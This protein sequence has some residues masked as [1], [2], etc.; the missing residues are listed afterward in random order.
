MRR[1]HLGRDADRIGLERVRVRH[2][3]ADE[4]VAR[5]RDLGDQMRDQAPGARLDRRDPAVES[6]AT[7][8]ETRGRRHQVVDVVVIGCLDRAHRPCR[9]IVRHASAPLRLLRWVRRREQPRLGHARL[10]ERAE[11]GAVQ[12][13]VRHAGRPGPDL[14]RAPPGEGQRLAVRQ[15]LPRG[16]DALVDLAIDPDLDPRPAAALDRDDQVDALVGD[17]DVA[18]QRDGLALGARGGDRDRPVPGGQLVRRAVGA[19]IGDRDRD[20]RRRRGRCRS[21]AACP[22]RRPRRARRT[23]R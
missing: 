11:G 7:L 10:P 22:G 5:P 17:R 9:P 12:R 16:T 21:R 8:A 14:D 4:P 6:K 18:R 1:K 20:R 23:W 15:D 3:A 19:V 2:E 13:E